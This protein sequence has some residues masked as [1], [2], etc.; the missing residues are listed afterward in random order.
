MCGFSHTHF[1][2][3]PSSHFH[4]VISLSPSPPLSISFLSFFHLSPPS[5]PS[6]FSLSPPSFFPFPLHSLLFPSSF[7]SSFEQLCINYCNEKLQQLFIELVL[8]QEQEEYMREGIQ[9]VKVGNP[10]N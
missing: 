4:S 6:L 9:W 1:S 8:K 3:F 10:S 7:L 2:S 5:F